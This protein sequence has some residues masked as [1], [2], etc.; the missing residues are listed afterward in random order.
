M[1]FKTRSIR[2]DE[3]TLERFKAISEEFDNQS[4]AL[5]SLINAYELQQSKAVLTDVKTDIEDFDSHLNSIQKGYLHILELNQNAE[6]RIRG[7]FQQQLESKDKQIIDLQQRVD[8]AELS[9]KTSEDTANTLKATLEEQSTANAETLAIINE[10]LLVATNRIDTLETAIIDKQVIIDSL[11]KQLAT[12][13]EQI[14]KAESALTQLDELQKQLATAETTIKSLEEKLTKQ[15]EHALEQS[16]LAEERAEINVQRAVLE[17][18]S[19]SQ[20]KIEQL[21]QHNDELVTQRANSQ[22][23]VEQLIQQ[24]N[25]LVTQVAELNSQIATQKKKEKD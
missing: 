23:K 6:H 22:T 16:K 5:E 11:N 2:A 10:K 25:E 9:A 12:A 7:E 14:D 21:M 13:T 1:D 8:K 20:G 24:N 18:R 15:E 3:N 4:V 17:E 19:K